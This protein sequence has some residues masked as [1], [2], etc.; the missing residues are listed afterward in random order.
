MES[1]AVE[2]AHSTIFDSIR[3]IR[4]KKKRPNSSN[5]IFEACEKSNLKYSNIKTAFNSLGEGGVSTEV[6]Y[7]H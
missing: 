5:V 4:S 7:M 2:R 6:T 1:A 3:H